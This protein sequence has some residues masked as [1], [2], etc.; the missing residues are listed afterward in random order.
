MSKPVKTPIEIHVN[1]ETRLV[2]AG[3]S[4][5]DLLG[6]LKIKTEHT[7]VELNRTILP[8]SNYTQA[9]SEGDRLEI[10]HFVGGG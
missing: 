7:A 6:D 5:A 4:V 1:G 2:K 10:V 3:L 9:L 8:K